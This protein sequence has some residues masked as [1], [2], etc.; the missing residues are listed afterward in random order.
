MP[1]LGLAQL[2]LGARLR[3]AHPRGGHGRVGSAVPVDPDAR[4][5]C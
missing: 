1:L 3:D 5:A 2:R 4:T